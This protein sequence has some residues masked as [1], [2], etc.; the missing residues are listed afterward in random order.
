MTSG[1]DN[2][3]DLLFFGSDQLRIVLA[4]GFYPNAQRA[5]FAA[6]GSAGLDVSFQ[7]RGCNSVTGRF[8]V[9]QAVFGADAS[10]NPTIQRFAATFIQHCEGLAPQLRGTFYFDASGVPPIP[11]VVSSTARPIPAVSAGGAGAIAGIVAI[12]G[13]LRSRRRYRSIAEEQP[14]NVRIVE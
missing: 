11:P 9:T 12:L 14:P 2:T 8:E 13:A 3:F 6:P 10:G 5:D 7:N 4:S 1:A